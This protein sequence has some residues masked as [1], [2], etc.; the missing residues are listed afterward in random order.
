MRVTQIHNHDRIKFT[1][2]SIKDGIDIGI[3]MVNIKKKKLPF[4]IQVE[5]DTGIKSIS[6]KPDDLVCLLSEI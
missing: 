6:I 1:P 4:S 2:E 5:E 3:M